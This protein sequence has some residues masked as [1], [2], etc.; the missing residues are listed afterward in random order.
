MRLAKASLSSEGKCFTC[1][2]TDVCMHVLAIVH[3]CMHVLE[4][5]FLFVLQLISFKY[6]EEDGV[7]LVSLCLQPVFSVLL[8]V[9]L[10]DFGTGGEQVCARAKP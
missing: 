5:M 10:D 1:R 6:P 2:Q 7:R 9:F 4:P 3:E 8:F